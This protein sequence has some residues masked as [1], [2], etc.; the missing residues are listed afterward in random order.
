MNRSLLIFDKPIYKL[1][2]SKVNFYRRKLP[3]LCIEFASDKGKRLF[4]EALDNDYMNVYFKLGPQ[5]RTQ[6]EPAYCGLSSLVMLLNGLAIDPGKVWK[7][8]WRWY[9]EN[10]LEC[11]T[12]LSE[13]KEKGVTMDQ[14]SC[15]AK[16]NQLNSKI[17]YANENA[18]VEDFRN[19]VKEVCSSDNSGI[20]VSFGRNVLQ[21]TGTGHF[22]PIG[23]Y[24]PGEDHVLILEPARFKYSPYWVH[25]PLLWKAMNT[26]DQN[27]GKSR[28]YLL[29]TRSSDQPTLIF[30]ISRL[31]NVYNPIAIDSSFS[32]YTGKMMSFLKSRVECNT[33]VEH[34]IETVT[35]TLLQLSKTYQDVEN[36]L[37]LSSLSRESLQSL[38]P[39]HQEAI[40]LLVEYIES[41]EVYKIIRDSVTEKECCG[42]NV[43]DTEALV[44]GNNCILCLPHFLAIMMHVLDIFTPESRYGVIKQYP[45]KKNDY[46][47]S[48]LQQVMIF[49]KQTNAIDEEVENTKLR[50]RHLFLNEV[51]QLQRQLYNILSLDSVKKPC[52]VDFT[53]GIHVR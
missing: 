19:N 22:S 13:V 34:V 32:S 28:G 25:L 43:F 18:T 27:T 50:G 37:L 42:Q 33:S 39:N 53:S 5:L 36:G 15:I 41:M 6:D 16:C 29:L 30:Q 20:I 24:H 26:V 8:V 47:G 21:Q 17:V 11:C 51:N 12:S 7:G 31:L 35:K 46:D 14:L 44:D 40:S 4:K 9:H 38:S 48:I 23:G 49:I 52:C 45:I 10:M 1:M 2:S 3:E